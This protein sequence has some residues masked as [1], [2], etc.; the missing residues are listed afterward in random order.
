MDD[1]IEKQLDEIMADLEET[2]KENG[3]APGTEER[4]ALLRQLAR[5][6]INARQVKTEHTNPRT[7][8]FRRAP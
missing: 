3:D 4:K 8:A 5:G 2:T 6:K 7:I 1:D